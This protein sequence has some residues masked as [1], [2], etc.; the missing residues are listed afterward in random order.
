[1]TGKAGSLIPRKDLPLMMS[2]HFKIWQ[3]DAPTAGTFD[4]APKIER[5]IYTADR[6]APLF[7]LPAR[8]AIMEMSWPNWGGDTGLIKIHFGA[9]YALNPPFL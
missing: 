8:T 1:M 3:G 4:S 7:P 5:K 6:F 2:A 9:T